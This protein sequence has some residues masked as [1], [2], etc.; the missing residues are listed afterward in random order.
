[1]EAMSASQVA[2]GSGAG[3]TAP[4]SSRLT[5]AV[6]A[7][8]TLVYVLGIAILPR[9]SFVSHLWVD[10][11]WT[12]GAA[13][14]AVKCARCAARRPAGA[15]RSFF[16]LLSAGCTSW[17]IGMLY[18]D[19]AELVRRSYTPFPSPAVLFFLLALPCFVAAIWVRG[20]DRP[21]APLTL[22]QLGDFGTALCT[23]AVVC[24]M[25][26]GAAGRGRVHGELFVATAG[27][28]GVASST[29][30]V[31][32]LLSVWWR[33][34]SLHDL[35]VVLLV[36]SG[37]VSLA[38][39]NTWYGYKLLRGT[40]EAG[41]LLDALWLVAFLL[42]LAAA[43]EE[44]RDHSA[45]GPRELRGV[46][47]VDAVVPAAVILAIAVAA[48][49][50]GAT[51]QAPITGSV[52]GWFIGLALALAVRG[53]AIMRIEQE[54]R[55]Q[56]REHQ[57][58]FVQAQKMEAVGT[59]AGGLAHDFNN[60]LTGALAGVELLR[61]RD[62]L[63]KEQVECVELIERSSERAAD[64]AQRLLAL[65]RR[66][67][68]SIGP[69]QPAAVVRV[70]AALLRGALPDSVEIRV[71]EGDR[72]LCV[73]ADAHELEQALL[74]L[75]IN[76]GHAMDAGGRL[77]LGVRTDVAANGVCWL[78]FTVSDTGTGI[79]PE[80]LPRIFE[81]F[82]TTRPEGEGTGLGLPMVRVAAEHHGGTIGV[83]SALGSGSTFT[84][85]IPLIE[86]SARAPEEVKKPSRF[87]TGTERVLVVDDRAGALLA[88]RAVL[89]YAGY[90]VVAASSG[91]DA[92]ALL[93]SDPS[94]A[95]VLTDNMM[96]GM[97]G[98][99]LIRAV[100]SEKL[101]VG[102]VLMTAFGPPSLELSQLDALVEK[103]FRPTTL[104]AVV[105][106]VLDR[107]AGGAD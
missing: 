14:P 27:V 17:T 89:E 49:A 9:G 85:S 48:F 3:S 102:V 63:S 54:L 20:V 35:R 11:G 24:L 47:L 26:Y 90:S 39:V 106:Q 97:S 82:F 52:L 60:V 32:G 95:L 58:E 65:S 50:A 103:P 12:L 43:Y 92:L 71:D 84:L 68:P 107:R 57:R 31:F 56:V 80:H 77:E 10:V 53:I 78:V 2:E 73:E 94:I 18:W 96:P 13:A 69:T 100:R 105:R 19:Y 45:A 4:T 66:S 51:A 25:T 55:A 62:N 6:L 34:W 42:V 88:A 41:L 91:A 99:A 79:A 38:V 36:L 33:R 86:A 81:P 44:E 15:R 37:L 28:Y 5:L 16:L 98:A 23:A 74:N 70:V 93:R 59:L 64:L 30:F 8:L 76:A 21:S 83:D 7:A 87:P 61:L 46:S 1:L 22:K 72:E 67:R 101:P 40:Y 75:G 104:A 29:A